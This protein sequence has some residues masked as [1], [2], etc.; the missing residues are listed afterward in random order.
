[1]TSIVDLKK[2]QHNRPHEFLKYLSENHD[3]TVLSINDWCKGAQGDLESYASEFSDIFN[4]VEYYYLTEKRVSPV[5]QELFFKNKIKKV[6]KEG[7]DVHFNYNSLVAGYEVARRL[8]T[9]FDLADDLVAMIRESPQIPSL[10]KPFGGYLGKLSLEKNVEKAEMVTLTTEELKKNYC[11]PDEKVEIIPNGVD[12]DLFRNH[13]GAKEDLGL[14]GFIIGYVGVLR[15]WVDLEP[16]FKALRELNKEI[17]MIVVGKEGRFCENLELAKKHGVEHRVIF[18]GMIPYSKIPKYVSAMDV[19]L[20][21]FKLSAISQA[22]LPLKLFEYGACERPIIS[23]EIPAVKAVLG[24]NVLYASHEKEYREKIM[25]LYQDQDLRR[26][27]GRKGREIVEGNY[28]WR[29]NV[30]KLESVLLT[31]G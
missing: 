29:K 10:L 26:R 28:N 30:K 20:I 6:L 13:D 22:A 14:D 18:T 9:V 27:L 5:F 8:E 31:V 21:P 19:C 2:S 4:R 1:M 12:T 11:I 25:M 23:A 16:V 17:K 7:F 15:E 24:D 3:V